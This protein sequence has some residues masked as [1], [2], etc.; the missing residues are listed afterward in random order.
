MISVWQLAAF[1]A[2]TALAATAV[3]L[4]PGVALAWLLARRDFA[5]KALV[6][7][8]VSLPLVLPMPRMETP[9]RLALGVVA[10][11]PGAR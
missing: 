3:M 7:T 11:R 5:G 8:A 10:V 9:V 2:V 6:E 4:V 1:T